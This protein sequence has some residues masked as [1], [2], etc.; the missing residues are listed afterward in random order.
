MD[1]F[2]GLLKTIDVIYESA[3]DADLWPRAMRAV[4][5]SV[6]ATAAGHVIVDP[7]AGRIT[8]C[9]TFDIQPSFRKQYVEYYAE[10]EVRL[11]PALAHPLG[12]ALTEG[13][14]IDSSDL[15]RSEIFNDLLLPCDIPFFMMTWIRRGA[16]AFE[17]V[18]V[19][20]SRTHGAFDSQARAR[21]ALLIPHLRRALAL[22][23]T[24]GAIT[25]KTDVFASI[26]DALSFGVVVLD[27]RGHVLES[28]KVA[29]AILSGPT[30]LSCLQMRIRA[31]DR[32]DDSRLQKAISATLRGST[33]G[34]VPG[35]T[36]A[37]TKP[38]GGRPFVITVVPVRPSYD[39][40]GVAG[41]AA[42]LFI[43]DPDRRATLGGA[44]LA[45]LYRLTPAEIRLATTLFQGM[46]LREAAD[47]LQVSLNTC[48]TQLKSIYV[49]TAT[50][51]QADLI[52][53]LVSVSVMPT[54]ELWQS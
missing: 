37:V 48:K 7:V 50:R 2:A 4:A 49:K 8:D 29:S 41:A 40:L 12:V 44:S 43:V 5:A 6:G 11:A 19:E 51:S 38:R 53:L 39:A 1:D 24:L 3:L 35:A 23:A 31:L 34:A 30:G 27:S 15:K 17:T 13:M 10:K 9:A 28:S 47:Q 54:H 36:L 16:E 52:K 22:R 20:G 32:N 21:F 33:S 45:T 25:F 42:L 26:V 14:L 46:S 18:A